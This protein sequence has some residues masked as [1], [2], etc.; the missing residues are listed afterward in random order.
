VSILRK[1]IHLAAGFAAASLLASAAMAGKPP[2][3]TLAACGPNDITAPSVTMITCTGFISGNL[4]NQKDASLDQQILGTLPYAT[5]WDGKIADVA[6]ATTQLQKVGSDLVLNFGTTLNGVTVLA[7]HYGK[8]NGTNGPGGESTAFYVLDA[9]QGVN[10]LH[11]KYSATFSN[12]DLFVTGL[13]RHVAA[14]PEPG[15]W[16]TMIMGFGTI[17]FQMRRRKR[18]AAARA[19]IEAA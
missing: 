14:A 17:G 5:G 15:T 2:A 12:A 8:G 11:L 13:T 10:Q 4:L 19:E 18:A 7:L 16:I 6:A 1:S 3:P 9:A